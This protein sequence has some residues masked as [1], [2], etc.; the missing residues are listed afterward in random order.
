MCVRPSNCASSC[1]NSRTVERIVIKF[2]MHLT[3][4]EANP[5]SYLSFFVQSVIPSGGYCFVLTEKAWVQSQCSRC[6]ICH[7]R[8][9][10]EA[11][12][13]LS[14]SGFPC[15]FSIHQ[16]PCLSSVIWKLCCRPTCGFSTKRLTFTPQK[17]VVNHEILR[18]EV[19]QRYW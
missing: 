1:F 8:S 16:F 17:D 6:G 7:G 12:S 11:G 15:Q 10:T 9:S 14:T 18:W 2:N 4:S 19:F 5:N 13:S 3:T